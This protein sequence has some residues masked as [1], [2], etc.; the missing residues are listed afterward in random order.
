M[1]STLLC[2]VTIVHN[3]DFIRRFDNAHQVSNFIGFVPK[4]DNSC[5]ICRSGHTTKQGNPLYGES[6]CSRVF[7]PQKGADA[8]MVEKLEAGCKH[9]AGLFNKMRD[10]DFAL[11]EGAGAAGGLGFA[12]LAG[13]NGRLESGI[14]MV[15]DLCKFEE[16]L[17]G[18][19]CIVTGEG[20]FDGQSLMGKVIGSLNERAG[21]A[22]EG[23]GKNIPLYVFCG[24]NKMEG[25][26][27]GIAEIIE[28]SAGQDRE[29]AMAHAAE[30][31]EAAAENWAKQIL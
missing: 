9:V 10:K 25:L 21:K 16:K 5:T 20:S 6:G 1:W 4:V 30:N 18:C 3:N 22:A 11:E 27:G 17:Q 28:I 29:Y 31:L 24:Q 23:T 13:L 15:L 14:G 8:A 26:P 12:I 2:N 19:D 7:G